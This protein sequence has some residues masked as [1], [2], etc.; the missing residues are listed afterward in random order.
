MDRHRVWRDQQL[1]QEQDKKLD[2]KGSRTQARRM[3]EE[4][5]LSTARPELQNVP[6][7]VFPHD[8]FA[9]SEKAGCNS[10]RYLT[11]DFRQI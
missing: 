10:Q 6:A 7:F 5:S 4:S 2:S 9:V 8:V 1:A 11:W 3:S